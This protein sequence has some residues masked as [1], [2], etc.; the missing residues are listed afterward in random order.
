MSAALKEIYRRM[1]DRVGDGNAGLASDF[2]DLA[3]A[4][5]RA[6]GVLVLVM[7]RFAR[8]GCGVVE[9]AICCVASTGRL[10]S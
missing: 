3:H 7:F 6:G 4:K 1:P 2:V 9:G 10:P 8:L 5:V